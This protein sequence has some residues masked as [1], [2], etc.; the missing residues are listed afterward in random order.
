MIWLIF[1][2]RLSKIHHPSICFDSSFFFC[3]F[4]GGEGCET[5]LSFF[6]FI[7]CFKSVPS[8]EYRWILCNCFEC[9][10]VCVS[11]KLNHQFKHTFRPKNIDGKLMWNCYRRSP[12]VWELQFQFPMF[13]F[14]ELVLKLM[15]EQKKT[16]ENCSLAHPWAFNC[17]W[18]LVHFFYRLIIGTFFHRTPFCSHK[19]P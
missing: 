14:I 7:A 17:S 18:P 19:I 15:R 3:T 9:I 5:H 4:I 12:C 16:D 10:G 2:Q 6:L 11:C 13:K 8:S 1:S